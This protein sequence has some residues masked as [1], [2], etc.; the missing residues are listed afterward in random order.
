MNRDTNNKASNI[1]FLS[2]STSRHIYNS[3][4]LFL[5]IYLN[6]YKLIIVENKIIWF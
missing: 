4:N 5:D 3:K 2:S 1:W 6:N